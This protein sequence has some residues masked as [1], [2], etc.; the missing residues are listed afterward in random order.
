MADI[1]A[2]QPQL[3]ALMSVGQA[4][5]MFVGASPSCLAAMDYSTLKDRYSALKVRRDRVVVRVL[6]AALI[7]DM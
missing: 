4:L 5:E 7:L 3:E 2:H 1:E 6:V